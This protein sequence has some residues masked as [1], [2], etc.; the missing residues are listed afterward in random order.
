MKLWM[1]RHPEPDVAPGICYGRTDL[2]PLPGP[3][4]ELI[5]RLRRRLPR[6]AHLYSSPLQRCASV[7]LALPDHGFGAP[8]FDPRLAEMH[9]GHWEGRPWAEL[10]REEV[11]AWRADIA[12]YVPPGGESVGEV[13]RRTTAFVGELAHAEGD[14]VVLITHAGVIQILMK[15]LRGE[16]LA[17]FGMARLDYGSVSLLRRSPQGF[18]VLVLNER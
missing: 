2:A 9:F 10:P 7:A 14:D 15:A 16:P 5:E 3:A 6:D 8:R 4:A 18:E 12:N 17:G 1:V 11:G 13:A